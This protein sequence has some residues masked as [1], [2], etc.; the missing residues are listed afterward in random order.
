VRQ[1]HVDSR[2]ISTAADPPGHYL[3]LLE[4]PGNPGHSTN[5]GIPSVSAACV[6]IR[7][8]PGTNE[9]LQLE[10]TPQSVLAQQ[11]HT[12]VSGHHRQPNHH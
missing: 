4:T 7:T 9:R 2:E 1:I 8:A 12:L 5:Q 3:D 11:V 10:V 6:L